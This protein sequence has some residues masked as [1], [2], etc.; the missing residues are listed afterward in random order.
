VLI[1]NLAASLDGLSSFASLLGLSS[2]S[3]LFDGLSAL[4]YALASAVDFALVAASLLGF[5][6]LL[7]LLGFFWLSLPS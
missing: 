5:L 1:W 6:A 7:S 4:H 2:S 3:A